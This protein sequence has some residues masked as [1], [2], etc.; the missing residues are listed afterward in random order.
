MLLVFLGLAN[1][2][3]FDDREQWII[4]IEASMQ[5]TMSLMIWLKMLYFLRIFKTTGYLIR[6][7]IEVVVDMRH[8]LFILLLTFVAFGDAM[9]NINTSNKDVFINDGYVGSILYV[10]RMVL[11]DFDTSAFGSVAVPYMWVL[12][13]LCTVFNMIIMLNLLIAIISESF[14]RIN[15]EKD[16]ASY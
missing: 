2:K 15:E 3:F 16:Q 12:F 8:F 14:A 7:I 1:M 9:Y 4:T 6:I 11:G 10:Y 13:L 5:A